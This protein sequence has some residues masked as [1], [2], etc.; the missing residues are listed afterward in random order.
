MKYVLFVKNGLRLSYKVITLIR[1]IHTSSSDNDYPKLLLIY[2]YFTY[3]IHFIVLFV[4]LVIPILLFIIHYVQYWL[5]LGEL[6]TLCP[7]ELLIFGWLPRS[8]TPISSII[9]WKNVTS[10]PIFF[11]YSTYYYATLMAVPYSTM[12]FEI[13]WF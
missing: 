4:L 8:P 12:T 2:N 7:R 13:F 3:Y 5:L 9:C 10:S 11:E 6:P 1:F